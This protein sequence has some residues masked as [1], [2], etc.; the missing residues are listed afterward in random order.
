MHLYHNSF[1]SINLSVD[2]V[3]NQNSDFYLYHPN[4]PR[5]DFKSI[6]IL[7]RTIFYTFCTILRSNGHYL[8]NLEKYFPKNN[9]H[10]ID[11][12][13]IFL[14]TLNRYSPEK[15]EFFQK[16]LFNENV[17]IFTKTIKRFSI[18]I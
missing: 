16:L 8:A 6:K 4:S 15:E 10:Q 9:T 14:S 2:K 11:E 12:Y 3:C 5:L 7:E 13:P 18:Y 1:Y 17:K